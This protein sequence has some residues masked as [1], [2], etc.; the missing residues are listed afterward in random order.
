MKSDVEAESYRATEKYHGT[1]AHFYLTILD[2]VNNSKNGT[3]QIWK[4]DVFERL[5]NINAK[6]QNSERKLIL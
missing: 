4:K 1:K 6:C 5:R 3:R 2:L